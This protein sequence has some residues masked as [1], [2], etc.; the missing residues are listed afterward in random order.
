[1]FIYALLATFKTACATLFFPKAPTDCPSQ[2]TLEA[3][4]LAYRFEGRCSIDAIATLMKRD[5]LPLSSQGWVSQC[6]TRIGQALPNTLRHESDTIKWVVFANDEV[7]AKAQP[8]LITVDP[9]SSA[10]LRIEL[11]DNRCAKQWCQ[12]YDGLLANGFQPIQLTSDGGVGIR[13]ANAE[14]FADIPWQ[15]DTF[16]SVAHRLG[17][18]DRRLEKRIERFEQR[19]AQREAVLESAKSEAVIDKRLNS[20]C[21]RT[22]VTFIGKLFSNSIPLIPQAS[23]GN[24][25]RQKTPS[26]QHW[27]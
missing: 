10:I 6:L 13:A 25:I 23:C 9:I 27:N 19:A 21:T 15:L 26:A 8:I 11:A 1:V 7:Y 18:W 22:S 3:R 14:K 17:D 16:H 5:E 20:R 12:H 24:S 2:E 4:V